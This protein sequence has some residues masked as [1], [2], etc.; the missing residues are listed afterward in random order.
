MTPAAIRSAPVPRPVPVD[1]AV[2]AVFCAAAVVEIAAEVDAGPAGAQWT[3][4]I[5]TTVPLAWRTVCPLPVVIVTAT[6]FLLAALIGLEPGEPLVATLAPLLAV[7]SLGAHS[8]WPAIGGGVVVA[9]AG[10]VLARAAAGDL[11]GTTL[12]L[13]AIVTAL[14]AGRAVRML[15]FETDVLEAR[16]VELERERDEQARAAVAAER[17]RIARELHDVIGHSISVMGVQ[18]GAVRRRLGA[19]QEREREALEAVERVG[20]DAVAEMQRLL[21]FLRDDGGDSARGALPTLQRVGELVAQLRRAGLDVDLRLE[22]DVDDLPP[23]RALAAFRVVQEAL[24]NVLKHAAGA[25]V[26]V[27]VRRSVCELEIEVIDDGGPSAGDPRASGGYGL[28]AMRER[29]AMYGGTL[30]ARP[31]PEGGFAVS[32]RL[33]TG[34]P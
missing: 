19:G 29:V 21:G 34:A 24:T 2:A 18:A 1:V 8:G 28:V 31:R 20:R 22:G 16:A 30:D 27:T 23:G 9:L 4:A 32:A 12:T 6:G 13:I 25:H 33:P 26:R 3:A 5:S 7:Y 11:A 14:T 17:A 15:G 10:A